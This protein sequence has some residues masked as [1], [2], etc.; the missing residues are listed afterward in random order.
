MRLTPATPRVS[1]LPWATEDPLFYFSTPPP[2]LP[3]PSLFSI[4]GVEFQETADAARTTLRSPCLG[5]SL[6]LD[7]V[8]YK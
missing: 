1:H 8:R 5:N 2:P 4:F 3:P 7:G 6:S